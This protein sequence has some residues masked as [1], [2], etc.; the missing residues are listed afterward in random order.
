MEVS[1]YSKKSHHVALFSTNE[2][3]LQFDEPI[4]KPIAFSLDRAYLSPSPTA[5]TFPLVAVDV[6]ALAYPST[7]NAKPS[8]YLISLEPWLGIYHFYKSSYNKD[9]LV[10]INNTLV[11]SIRFQLRNP[12]GS[13]IT[14]LAGTTCLIHFKFYFE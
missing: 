3:T 4:E 7:L 13:L 5:P 2:F 14:L 8:P 11:K 12:D 9:S 10:P 6:Q 1:S